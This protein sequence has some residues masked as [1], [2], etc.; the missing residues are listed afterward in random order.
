MS[1]LSQRSFAG[2]ELTPSLQAKCD[3]VKYMTGA[4]TLRRT[5]IRKEGGISNDPGS[6]FVAEVKDSTKTV[7][8]VPFVLGSSSYML[9]IGD[10]YV[11]FFTNGSQI[12]ESGK[13]I[14]GITK[15]NPAVV[16]SAAHGFNNGDEVYISGVVGM[17]EIN[18]RWFKVANKAANT[19]ELTSLGGN[20]INSAGYTS[21][22]SAGTAER[23]YTI[24][25]NTWA[26]SYLP[27]LKITFEAPASLIITVAGQ[28]ARKLTRTSDTSWAISNLSFAG[29]T[30]G[31]PAIT[32]VTG[33]GGAIPVGYVVTAFNA[34]TGEE[35]L[36][37]GAASFTGAAA[38]SGAPITI[39][40]GAV[41]GA[42]EY[43]V[44]KATTNGAFGLIGVSGPIASPQFTDTGQ[45]IDY[46]ISYPQL[47]SWSGSW[48]AC[49][50]FQRRLMLGGNLFLP[51]RVIGSRTGLP[52]NH[53]LS[54]PISPADVVDIL[55]DGGDRMQQVWSMLDLG[56]L[57]V[58]TS[59]GEWVLQGD[60]QGV[61]TPDAINPKEYSGYGSSYISPI[62]IGT[63]AL[64]V[65]ACGN[66]V[67]DLGFDIN[68]DG[69]KGNDLTAFAGHL[70]KN[71]SITDM[72]YQKAPHSIVWVVVS[73]GDARAM[74]YIK[75]HEIVGWTRHDTLGSYK[76][77]CSIPQGTKDDLYQVVERSINGETK[78]YIELK[79][80]RDFSDI[81][82]AVFMDCAKTY[83]GRN[84]T[85]TT[86]TLSG[87]STW[88][89][90]ET[91]TITASAATFSSSD[92]GKEIHLVGSD[93]TLIQFSLNHYTSSTVMTGRPDRTVPVA[94]RSV[95]VTD[96]TL[97]I[98]QVTGL[99]HL[100]GEDVSVFADGYVVGSPNNPDYPTYTVANGTIDL[101]RCFG[102]IHVGLPYISD[103]ETLNI[104]SA[105]AETLSDK[106]MIVRSVHGRVEETRGLFIGPKP[107]SDDDVDPL[108]G[109]R[110]VT[111]R[112]QDTGY[113]SPV[114][115]DSD[116]FETTI[117]GEWNS[118][119]RVFIRQVDPLPFTI[120]S[121]EP[122]GEFP[123]RR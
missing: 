77:F 2:G 50:Y 15:A 75:E 123:V 36:P 32:S 44:Y 103:A 37:S 9:E 112:N 54:D 1:T 122:Q 116:S 111:Q 4:R 7:R 84:S 70:F 10:S 72:A 96:W 101:D 61:L 120:L 80:D 38:S 93:G 45:N 76:N 66:I 52:T 51:S 92:V 12:R 65:Q 26:E 108:E 94:M 119:G 83:D 57:V 53:L 42:T 117:P 24:T 5:F 39:A 71:L 87:G 82:D 60:N 58:F 90:D 102:V 89:Y 13:T 98:H 79:K 48:Q 106:R 115:L 107:P 97:A 8:L 91:I 6:G 95:A 35:S 81:V 63:S 40:W 73:S 114:S 118:N 69:Y 41:S 31:T 46:S 11:R 56:N 99:W 28:S 88:A 86:M 105:N 74:T 121:I 23:V 64:F 49:A 55:L 22:S 14:T 100:E 68:V 62:K 25:A 109:L 78:K 30:I 85:A 17:T 59:Q 20:N 113:D 34:Q 16:T 33:T 3:L 104:D 18:G 67:R 27:Y 19:F 29:T 21:Y 110:P 47:K 43:N